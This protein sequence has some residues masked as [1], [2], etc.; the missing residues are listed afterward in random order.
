MY[1]FSGSYQKMFSVK[2]SKPRKRKNPGKEDSSAR[3]AKRMKVKDQRRV[4]ED[5]RLTAEQ[6]ARE[7]PVQT[8]EGR[9]FQERGLQKLK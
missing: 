1:L 8:G 2:G 6:Q 3:G 4:K 5:P 7:Q 9:G